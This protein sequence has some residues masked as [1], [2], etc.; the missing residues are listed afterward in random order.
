M[1]QHVHSEGDALDA[2]RAQAVFCKTMGHPVRLQILDMLTRAG[3]EMQSA[4]IL[5][6]TGVAKPCL[7]QHLARMQAAG[8]VKTRRVGRYL[9]VAL[10]CPEVGLACRQVRAA[11]QEARPGQPEVDQAE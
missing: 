4:E 3:E 6:R 11:L 8:L 9:R 5:R 2:Y 1:I 10:T 7:S